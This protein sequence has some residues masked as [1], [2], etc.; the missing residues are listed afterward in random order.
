MR[1]SCGGRRR[2]DASPLSPDRE[3]RPVLHSV[4]FCFVLFCEVPTI[5]ELD[6][7]YDVRRRDP[8]TLY[9]AVDKG[10]LFQILSSWI[11]GDGEN[12]ASLFLLCATANDNRLNWRIVASIHLARCHKIIS[13]GV[14]QQPRKHLG[15]LVPRAPFPYLQSQ[16]KAP[17]GL[18]GWHLETNCRR[19]HLVWSRREVGTNKA[20]RVKSTKHKTTHCATVAEFKIDRG[21]YMLARRDEFYVLVAR[22]ISHSFAKPVVSWSREWH[23][24]YLVQCE[25]CLIVIG[26]LDVKIYIIKRITW[27][28]RVRFGWQLGRTSCA[29]C[30]SLQWLLRSFYTLKIQV[31]NYTKRIL[32]KC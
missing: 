1:K 23:K 4:F 8:S 10:T 13:H 2:E 19:S 3:A 7:G 17:W 28:Q 25:H 22:T 5:W 12:Q 21:Y 11:V 20:C 27:W 9:R 31:N 24:S 32:V 15:S 14:A 16:G 18:I 6:T 30:W 26:S 29:L